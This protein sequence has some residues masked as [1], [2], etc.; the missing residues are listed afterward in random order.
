M[1]ELKSYQELLSNN[2]SSTHSVAF[3]YIEGYAMQ[4]PKVLV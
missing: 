4:A 3:P 2:N 1:I